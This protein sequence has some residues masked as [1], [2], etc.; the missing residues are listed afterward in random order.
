MT[1]VLTSEKVDVVVDEIEV[2][3]VTFAQPVL[4]L[5]MVVVDDEVVLKR[6]MRDFEVMVIKEYLFSDT[7][8]LADIIFLEE[9]KLL[10][11]FEEFHT[12]YIH[13]RLMEL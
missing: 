12:A 8:A 5:T 2:V 9:L 13:L 11:L 3:I 6:R 7:Q 1:I 4:R 10:Q